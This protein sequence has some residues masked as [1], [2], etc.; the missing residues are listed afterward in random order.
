[1]EAP[2]SAAGAHDTTMIDSEPPEVDRVT[3]GFPGA[4]GTP[5]GMAVA[6]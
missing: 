5:A 2:L 3:V 1:M 6:E 4:P